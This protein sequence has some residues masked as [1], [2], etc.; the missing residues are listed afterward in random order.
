LVSQEK[1]VRKVRWM[2]NLKPVK[3]AVILWDR[4]RYFVNPHLPSGGL[5]V[6]SLPCNLLWTAKLCES[7]SVVLVGE[8]HMRV[9]DPDEMVFEEGRRRI[10]ERP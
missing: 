1:A 6:P 10:V 5:G 2:G 8:R 4:L 7:R 3:P 9:R